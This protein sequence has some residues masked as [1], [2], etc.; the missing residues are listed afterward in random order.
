M[1]F[2]NLLKVDDDEIS[3]LQWDIDN[4]DHM[5]RLAIYFN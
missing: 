3:Y 5:D 4:S 2:V 1:F